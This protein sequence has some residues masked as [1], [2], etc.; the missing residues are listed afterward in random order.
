[1]NRG[2]IS[3]RMKRKGATEMPVGT[4]ILLIAVALIYFGLAHRILDRMRLS[5]KAALFFLVSMILGSFIDIPILRRPADLRINVGGGIVPIVLSGYLVGTSDSPREKIRAVIAAL[6]TGG[7]IFAFAKLLPKNEL[8]FFVEPTYLY[9]AVG[10]I[11]GYLAGRSRRASF[12]AG[13]LGV[14]L[15]DFGHFIEISVLRIPGRSLIG[16][17]GIFDAVVISG[18]IAVLLAEFVGEARE[19]FTV[20]KESEKRE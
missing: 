8:E 18:L 15:A 1:M 11:V 4:I 16:G 10:G 19:R 6:V 3:P 7:V 14:V 12:V 17:A 9:G 13:M 2:R 20:P 5:D